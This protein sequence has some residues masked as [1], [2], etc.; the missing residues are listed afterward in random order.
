MSKT[1]VVKFFNDQKGFGFILQD[2]NGD[3]LF[4]HRNSVVDGQNLV[5]GDAVSYDEAW[6]DRKGK[7]NAVN[8]SGGSGG[9]G[10][11][12]GKGFGG[13]KGFSGGKGFGGG[14]GFKGDGFG[15][16]KGFG[17][18]D[19]YS[20]GGGFGGGKSFG[21]GG[22]GKGKGKGDGEPAVYIGGL[23][24][25]TTTESLRYHFES[26]GTVTYARVMTDRESGKS[27]GCGKVAF[28]TEQ[29]RDD[30]IAQLDQSDLD[31]RTIS[32][33]AFT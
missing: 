33:R 30:A 23:S 4:A 28:S 14:K 2:D 6:D 17:G 16:G 7:S 32:V 11:G 15:G 5:E 19:G 3:D 12:G 20:G 1:G 27:R 22:K 26:Y 13:S 8:I 9:E 10:F 29:E 21:G 31:G 25:D 24:Y 18:G